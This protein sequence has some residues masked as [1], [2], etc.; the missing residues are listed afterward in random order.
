MSIPA[1][2]NNWTKAD[3]VLAMH[4]QNIP[5]QVICKKFDITIGHAHRMVEAGK[6]RR[7]QRTGCLERVRLSKH[8]VDQ[9]WQLPCDVLLP[10]IGALVTVQAGCELATLLQALHQRE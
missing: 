4:E 8:H 10:T 9:S 7:E 1:P 3:E 6:R 2:L 5:Y